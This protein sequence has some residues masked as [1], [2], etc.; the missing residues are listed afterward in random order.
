VPTRIDWMHPSYRDLVIDELVRSGSLRK[1]FLRSAG[2]EGIRLALSVSGGA[3]GTRHFPLM[4]GVLDWHLLVERCRVLC[5]EEKSVSHLLT[6]ALDATTEASNIQRTYLLKCLAELCR[7]VATI[8][9]S[10]A[11]PL[12]AEDIK[13]FY[14]ASLLISPLPPMPDFGL[15]WLSVIEG[16]EARLKDP[17]PIL[18]DF[19]AIS[20]FTSVLE[21]IAKS[22]P[23]FLTQQDFPGDFPKL[24]EELLKRIDR[25]GGTPFSEEYWELDHEAD[26]ANSLRWVIE[27]LATF[28]PNVALTDRAVAALEAHAMECRRQSDIKEEFASKESD[29][30]DTG[31]QDSEDDETFDVLALFADL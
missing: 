15:T 28:V 23:R 8:W 13:A 3:N 5:T 2:I 26:Q 17:E 21:L 27:R 9:N 12:S 19:M 31:E 20:E 30:D 22:E 4:I 6:I 18:T 10:A 25:E 24:H 16:F 14:K 11:H 29:P 7:Q 1:T